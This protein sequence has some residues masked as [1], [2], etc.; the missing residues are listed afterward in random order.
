M[1]RPKLISGPSKFEYTREALEARVEGTMIVRCTLTVEGRAQNCRIIKPLPHLEESV[2]ATIAK[3][4]YT[5]VTFQGR[6]VN[7]DYTFTFKFVLPNR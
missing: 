2:L 5:P 1:T 3:Q 4:R 6:P 7:V